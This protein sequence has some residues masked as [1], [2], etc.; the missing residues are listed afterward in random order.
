M[1]NIAVKLIRMNAPILVNNTAEQQLE[2]QMP[3]GEKAFWLFTSNC[4]QNI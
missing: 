3:S 1:I 2:F 4:I